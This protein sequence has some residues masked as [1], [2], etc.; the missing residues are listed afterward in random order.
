MGAL[1]F[2]SLQIHS[3]NSLS[4]LD[5]I[6]RPDTIITAKHRVK[7]TNVPDSLYTSDSTG[8]VGVVPGTIEK[9]V[10]QRKVSSPQR[11][12]ILSAVLPGLG[13]AYNHKYWKIPIFYATGA[14]LY[15]IYNSQNDIYLEYRRNYE[16]E[17][18]KEPAERD[19]NLI[20]SYSDEFG[21]AR[22][23]RDYCVIAMGV[24]YLANIVDAMADAYFLQYDISDDLTVQIKPSVMPESFL[25]SASFSYGIRLNIHF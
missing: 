12:T 11:A 20:D 3:Q 22:K 25:S 18:G 15:L 21:R 16:E 2:L 24:L 8:I 13:Q 6:S 23:R 9:T 1:F 5:T 10:R 17:R 4:Q 7:I 19:Q 14:G